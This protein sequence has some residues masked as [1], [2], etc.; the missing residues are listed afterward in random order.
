MAILHC[1]RYFRKQRTFFAGH[2]ST[3]Y[4][5]QLFMILDLGVVDYQEALK[6]QREFVN[7]RRLNEISDSIIIAQHP[8]VLTIGRSGSR[9]NLLVKENFLTG[10]GIKVIDVE[11][12][13]DITFHGPGQIVSYPILDLKNRSMDLHRYLRDLEEVAISFLKIYGVRGS[14][15]KEATGVW[16]D[17]SKIVSIGIAAKDWITYHGL[18]VNVNVDTG[19]FSMIN[20]CGFKDLKVTSL[21]DILSRRLP[22]REAKDKLLDELKNMFGP[23]IMESAN[24]CC[25][26]LA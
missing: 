12:G 1:L 16:V 14:R 13:G 10:N 23:K 11:R 2:R 3:A 17:E 25:S 15:K 5:L 8:P 9:D 20:P 24:E 22:M 7:K 4:N 26:A 21:K 19:F 6:T 18:S